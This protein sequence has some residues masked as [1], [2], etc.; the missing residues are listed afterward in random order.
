MPPK[1]TVSSVL[2]ALTLAC[3]ASC[4][5]AAADD[6]HATAG[7]AEV[8]STL[9]DDS[10]MLTAHANLP[11]PRGG[12]VDYDCLAAARASNGGD[13]GTIVVCSHGGDGTSQRVP[14][15]KSVDE[16]TR[17]GV[18]RAPDLSGPSTCLGPCITI[19][20]GRVPP[21]VYYID[22]KSIPEAPKGSDA[23]KIGQGELRAP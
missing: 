7:T 22:L 10:T 17:T 1:A 19:P 2:A 16:S 18:P 5:A 9:P 12:A 3:F 8:P 6:P 4:P 23:W 21:P 11:D 14:A 15:S 20:F 13:G